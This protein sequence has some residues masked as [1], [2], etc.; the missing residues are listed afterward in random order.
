M[1]GIH[2][3]PVSSSFLHPPATNLSRISAMNDDDDDDDDDDECLSSFTDKTPPKE[4]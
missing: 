3:P 1:I 4:N 2:S